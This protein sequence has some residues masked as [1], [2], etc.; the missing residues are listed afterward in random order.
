[1]SITDDDKYN[2]KAI[3]TNDQDAEGES[4]QTGQ[5]G[6]GGGQSGA[7]EFRDFLAGERLRDDL[8]SPD[9]KKRLLST[10]NLTHEGRYL[11]YYYSNVL[12][13]CQ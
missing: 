2:K 1:M 10:H 8:L 4:G 3:L 6:Q 12:R 5:T 7:I 9:E 11:I 13:C